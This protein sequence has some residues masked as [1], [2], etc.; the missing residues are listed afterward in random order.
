MLLC[1]AISAAM[2]PLTPSSIPRQVD[3]LVMT[4]SVKGSVAKTAGGDLVLSNGLISRTIRLSPNAATVSLA[5]LMTGEEMIRAVKPEAEVIIDGH[6]Y[7]IGGLVGQPDMAYLTSEWLQKMTSPKDAFNFVKYEVGTPTTPIKW[8]R[9]RHS[10]ERDWPPKGVSLTL[11]FHHDALKMDAE[12]HY[13][14]FDGIPAFTKW[15]VIKNG[16]GQRL[17]KFKNE[18]L[19]LVEG[20]SLVDKSGE[21]VKP[22][23]TALSDYAFGGM[24]LD[25]SIKG[26]RWSTDPEYTTQVNFDLLTPCLLEGTLPIGPDVDLDKT[27]VSHRV[28]IL[29]H[30][31]SERER[32]SLAIRRLYRV[33]A[34]WSTE[35]P[36]MLHLTSVDPKTV[37]TAIDQAAECGFE[38]IVISFWS[39]LEME[40]QS[41]ANFAK[42]REFREYANKKGIE[43]GGY[44]LLASRRIDDQ[45]DAINPKTGKP[46][47]AIFGS[48]PCLMSKWGDEYFAKIRRFFKETGFNLFEHDGSYPGDLCASTTHPG[49]RGVEDSQWKQWDRIR[50]LYADF[51]AAGIY[52]NVPDHYFLAGS[53]KTGMGYRESNWSL[54]RAQQHI[55]ARQNLFDGTYDRTPSMGWMMVPLV[56]YQGGG[57]EATIEPLHEHLAD[58]EMHLANNLAY[59]AQA[60]YR[61]PR[62]YDT[63]EVRDAVQKWVSWFKKYRGILESDVVHLRRPDGNR[64]DAILHVNPGLPIKGMLAVWNPSDKP[65]TDEVTVPLYYTG[66]TGRAKVSVMGGKSRSYKLERDYSIEVEV[67]VPAR[68]MAWATIQ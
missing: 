42:F 41:E 51:Q 26:I 65:V 56:E 63:P 48:S 28:T 16:Q 43:L 12:V 35:N 1:M 9:K 53:N 40:D 54:P 33:V 37:H 49:H 14:L 45:N 59:G 32:R 50:T 68:G 20:Q 6:D 66:L 17:S 67:T 13:D 15:L 46:G 39:G 8:K 58:Y 25:N 52:L 29:V 47:D 21:W 24:A 61:G 38:M 57:K 44:S 30:D 5:N 11:H 31:S 18:I 3:W 36:L 60:C 19:G 23:V 34:P 7:P 2:V 55:H 62:L 27:F 10:E 4:P 22:P 64:L